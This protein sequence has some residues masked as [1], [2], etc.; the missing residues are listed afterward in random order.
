[1]RQYVYDS[2]NSVMDVDKESTTTHPRLEYQT[3]GTTG[4]CMDVVYRFFNVGW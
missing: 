4:S 3:H 1:M 2:W